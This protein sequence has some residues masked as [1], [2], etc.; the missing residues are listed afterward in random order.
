MAT[1]DAKHAA[2]DTRSTLRERLALHKALNSDAD[3]AHIEHVVS[4]AGVMDVYYHER[5]KV[6]T[7]TGEV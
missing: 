7:S 6:S 2:L 4:I 3:T 5:P 1:A